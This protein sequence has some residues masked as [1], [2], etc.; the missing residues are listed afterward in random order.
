[1]QTREIRFSID[2]LANGSQVHN[3]GFSPGAMVQY[4]LVWCSQRLYRMQPPQTMRIKCTRYC[5]I[6]KQDSLLEHICQSSV[7]SHTLTSACA[8]LATLRSSDFRTCGQAGESNFRL[9]NCSQPMASGAVCQST[10]S[11]LEP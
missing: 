11:L 6:T 2:L 9:C 7:T 1:M 10:P 4:S 3:P 5:I 8:R